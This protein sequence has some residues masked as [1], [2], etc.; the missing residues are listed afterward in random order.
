MMAC[1][2]ECA[3]AGLG[4][5]MGGTRERWR[6]GWER[7]ENGQGSPAKTP[8]RRMRASGVRIRMRRGRA[9]LAKSKCG[10]EIG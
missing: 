9:S 3:K 6:R 5:E 10:I 4:S 1:G 7:E 8:M 2:G